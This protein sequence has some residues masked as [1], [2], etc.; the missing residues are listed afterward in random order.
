VA[1]AMA[2]PVEVMAS[3][4]EVAVVA[5]AAKDGEVVV[6]GAAAVVAATAWF[7][8]SQTGQTKSSKTVRHKN[9]RIRFCASVLLSMTNSDLN[10]YK[11]SD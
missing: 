10:Y 1:V 7:V 9:C 4:A 6:K 8:H 2:S 3:P 11:I 5:V